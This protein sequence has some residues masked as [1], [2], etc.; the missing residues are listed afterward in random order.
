MSTRLLTH[1]G[2]LGETEIEPTYHPTED[3]FVS[4]GAPLGI[5]LGEDGHLLPTPL[6]GI[7]GDENNPFCLRL[8]RRFLRLDFDEVEVWSAA[9]R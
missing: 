3:F 5:I 8:A 2:E 6:G 9:L 4:A 1:H 7:A